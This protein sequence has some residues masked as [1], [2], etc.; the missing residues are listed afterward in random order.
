MSAQHGERLARLQA[1]LEQ[2]IAS[3]PRNAHEAAPIAPATVI[4][5]AEPREGGHRLRNFR[6][7]QDGDLLLIGRE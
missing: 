7:G 1:L 3:D 6:A 2:T 5:H 4:L